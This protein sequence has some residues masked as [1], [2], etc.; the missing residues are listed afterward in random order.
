MTVPEYTSGYF[1]LYKIKTDNS[2]DYPEKYI[3][4]LKMRIWY[5]EISIFD[6]T[7]CEFDKSDISLTMKVRIPQYKGI[8]S[9][10]I[11]VIDGRQHKVY[12]ATHVLD[13]NGIPETEL[14]LITP[15]KEYEVLED[16]E[17]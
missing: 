12:N 1:D 15:E 7:R 4:N 11:C 17:D 3:K 13:K 2:T 10:C 5:R 8:D 16:D 14:T 6:K 9:D